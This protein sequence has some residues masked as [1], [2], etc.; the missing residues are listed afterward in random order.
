MAIAF[1]CPGCQKSLY[2]PDGKEGRPAT[3][4]N[5]GQKVT[6]PTSPPA[7]A[8]PTPTPEPTI[9]FRCTLCGAV[10][11]RRARFAGEIM[12]CPS[13]KERIM[14]PRPESEPLPEIAPVIAEIVK[15]DPK[16]RPVS[17][18]A[19]LPVVIPVNL[20]AVVPVPLPESRESH[21]APD[22]PPPVGVFRVNTWIQLRV[23]ARLLHW[24]AACAACLA[25]EQTEVEISFTRPAKAGRLESRSW[26]VPYCFGCFQA[27]QE[28][29]AGPA[30]IYDG[31]QSSVHTFRFWNAQY[32]KA[33]GEA[34]REKMVR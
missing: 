33:F 23:S 19:N 34:N 16:P 18:S 30:V 21:A 3:C 5:C 4:P 20:P 2:A 13:C 7:A 6:V 25:P 32:A 15:D 26:R 10:H 1:R 27:V 14:I 24:P 11:E 31:W 17:E 22:M 29:R 12:A 8:K 28:N 9:R